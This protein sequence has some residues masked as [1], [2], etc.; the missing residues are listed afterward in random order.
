MNELA[1]QFEKLCF[2]LTETAETAARDFLDQQ[3]KAFNDQVS[4]K[5]REIRPVGTRPLAVLVYHA[6]GRLVGGLA[7][8][9]YWGWLEIEDLWLP[10]Q[11][12]RQGIGRKLMQLA[13]QEAQDRG[14]NRAFLRTYSF[15]ARG[16]YEQLGYRIV[17]Q[18][19]DYPPDE[20]FYWLRK[21][22]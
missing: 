20:S 7:G 16:F 1:S 11:W 6:N 9:T 13:E 18:L 4:P 8:S 21:D 17:G 14:C 3:I 2:S 15:Q 10:E 19:D 12:R 22:F 5:H